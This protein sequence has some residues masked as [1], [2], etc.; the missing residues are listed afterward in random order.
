MPKLANNPHPNICEFLG[1]EVI[2]GK[3]AGICC[4]RYK[5]T[6]E[7]RLNPNRITKTQ[8]KYREGSLKDRQGFLDG[9]RA[10]IDHLHSLGFVHNDICPSNIMFKDDDTPV[11]ID[12]SATRPIGQG[13][14]EVTRTLDWFDPGNN[15]ARFE[16]D[17]DALA[18]LG[19]FLSPKAM[20]DWK[21]RF[22]WPAERVFWRNHGWK[23]SESYKE[24]KNT[25]E[26]LRAGAASAN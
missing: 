7:E 4:K 9:V 14:M 3:I 13:P 22:S 25:S 17:L 8:F 11:I 2:N 12:F 23:S 6:L 18:D 16:N 5:D 19:E 24:A 10:G 15:T 26:G 21:F 20:K 1:V